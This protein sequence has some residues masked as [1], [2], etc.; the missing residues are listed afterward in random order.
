VRPGRLDN[1]DGADRAFDRQDVHEGNDQLPCASLIGWK[2]SQ[3]TGTRRH[4]DP[5]K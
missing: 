2:L 3:W 1:E 5:A 4:R